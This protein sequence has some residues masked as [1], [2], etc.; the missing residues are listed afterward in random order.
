[1]AEYPIPGRLYCW[2]DESEGMTADLTPRRNNASLAYILDVLNDDVAR[3]LD[4]R[5]YDLK[6]LRF[7]IDRKK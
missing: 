4:E 6:T 7:T 3:I 2:W 5:G 1:M